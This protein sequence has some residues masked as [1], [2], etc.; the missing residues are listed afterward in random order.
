MA[1]KKYRFVDL[2]DPNAE[3]RENYNKVIL[4]KEL[5]EEDETNRTLSLRYALEST[6]HIRVILKR[7]IIATA[8]REINT[9]YM[10]NRDKE[11]VFNSC[12]TIYIYV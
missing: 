9:I 11:F 1:D 5:V 12:M 7:A 10:K 3:L 8:R 6:V 4:R 2:T